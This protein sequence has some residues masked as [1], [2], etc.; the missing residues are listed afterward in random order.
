MSAMQR[1]IEPLVLRAIEA[2]VDAREIGP[3]AWEVA[4]LVRRTIP[5]EPMFV[6]NVVRA[7]AEDGALVRDSSGLVVRYT[8]STNGAA[9]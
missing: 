5:V 3:T 6:A 8:M 9:R 7:L 4:R 2:Y 1:E